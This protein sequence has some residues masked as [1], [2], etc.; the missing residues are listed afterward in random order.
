MAALSVLSCSRVER[1]LAQRFA[2]NTIVEI[3]VIESSRRAAEVQNAM[4]LAFDAIARVEQELSWFEPSNELARIRAARPGE[5]IPVSPLLLGTLQHAEQLWRLTSGRYDVCAGPIIRAW[6]FGPGKTNREP[7]HAEIAEALRRSG[8]HNLALLPAQSAVSTCVAGVEIDVSSLAAGAAVDAAVDVLSR[9]GLRSF[10]VN[11]G[12]EIRVCS[13]GDKTWRIGIQIP[14]E[15]ARDSDYFHDRVISLKEGSIS[16]SGSYRNFHKFGS[17]VYVHIVDPRSGQPLQSDTVSV[18]TWAPD[19]TSA[20]AWSTALFTLP[21]EAALALTERMPDL[22][23][24]IVLRPLPGTT[25]FRFLSSAG[26]AART[27]N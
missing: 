22:E 16:T 20:D 26:F 15:T 14:E 4:D 12:G 7:T 5:L 8:M 17:N 18:T 6:G 23:C 1:F 21:A 27:R 25:T 19:C 24:L 13:D 3:Q 10:L 9:H 2:M 11:G